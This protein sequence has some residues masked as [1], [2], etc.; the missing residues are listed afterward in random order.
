MDW[1]AVSVDEASMEEDT[2]IVVLCPLPG[3]KKLWAERDSDELV[4][5]II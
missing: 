1:N 4:S 3:C 5:A 2:N